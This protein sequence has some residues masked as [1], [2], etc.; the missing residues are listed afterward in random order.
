MSAAIYIREGLNVLT[1]SINNIY[2]HS[3]MTIIL[4]PQVVTQVERHNQQPMEMFVTNK[5]YSI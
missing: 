1:L 4:H 5:N 2:A 3:Y